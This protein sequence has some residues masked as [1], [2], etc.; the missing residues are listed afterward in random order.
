MVNGGEGGKKNK[1][2]VFSFGTR[3]GIIGANVFTGL[4]QD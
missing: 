2:K 4:D 3:S 1:E